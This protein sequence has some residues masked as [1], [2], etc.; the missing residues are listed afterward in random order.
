[1]AFQLCHSPSTFFSDHHP[2]SNSLNSQHRIT[3]RKSSHRF[4]LNP[5][6]H[7]SKTC[8]RITNVSLQEYAAQEAQNPI[9]TQDES[10]KYPDGK[11]NSSSKSSV[12]VNPRSPR[13]SKLRNQSY[14]ARY[15]S[16]T[17]ISESLDSCNPCEEDVADVLKGMGSNILE[18]DAVAVLNNMSNS[19]TALLALQMFQK[20]LKSSKKAILYNVTLKVLR[21]SRDME[22]AEKLFD[23]MLKRGVK[24]D[25][26]TFSTV[27][28]CARLCSLPNK[29]VEWFEKMPSFDCN[30][31]DVTYSA[32]I[33]A[34]GRAGNVDMAFSL[35]DRARTENW[36]IDPATFS[37]LIKIHGVA[38]N[39]DGCLNV[40][41]EMKAIGIKPN[42]VIYNSLLDAM[43]RAKRPW[44][45]KTIYKEMIKNGFSPSWATYA[46][47]L[48]AYGRA[49]YGEDALLV[50]KEMKEKGLQLNVILYNTLLAMCADVGYV[51]EA[52]EIFEDMKS[53]GACSPDSWTF[54]SMITIYS[55][56]GKVSEA[57]EMLNEMMEAGFD[58]NIFVLTSLIQCYGK[59][60]RVDDVVRTF[61]RLVELGLTPDDRF[62][63]CL[64][65]VITQTPKEELSKLIDCV[66]RANSKLG[67]VV[68]LLL[69]EQDKEGDLRTEA[70]ELLSVVSAD[71]RKA[72]CNCLIDLC[73]NL[74]LLEKACELLDLGLTLQIYTGLQSTSPTQWSLHLKGLSLGAALTA[75]HVWINDLTKVLESGEELPPLL[76]INT[77]HGK[78]KYSD[79]GLASVFESHL[80]ELNA[81][82]HEAPEKVGWFLT[83]KVAAKSWLESRGSPELVAA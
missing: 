55:C 74:D 64:L 2:L 78:H 68:K 30:P 19:S 52:V 75:L 23:E 7:H 83:T 50:Y 11:S 47:L 32:M 41:E 33:D 40:Y 62:C 43:G 27:I 63:G 51:N 54:S 76:G 13:A 37:T 81:P 49:R 10:S 82:F 71:V 18:Q 66:E 20:V 25:N 48:R 46:S 38:G 79:K 4:K 3:L 69:G 22:G 14:E 17:R 77:G 42:L 21:K 26:V 36:R 80:K 9:P 34:Y 6:P 61:D 58:P 8:L 65:N 39:Y 67:Y 35:Y 70:S 12:W 45:I 56:S 24:P 53:S 15:A 59:G 29:A 16:L 73:V 31:D 57:E 5:T 60:K 72:Y 44:Q 28:S 1:M